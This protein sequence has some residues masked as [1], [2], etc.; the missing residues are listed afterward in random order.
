MDFLGECEPVGTLRTQALFLHEVVRR[1]VTAESNDRGGLSARLNRR[2]RVMRDVQNDFGGS[3]TALSLEVQFGDLLGSGEEHL[4]FD[5]NTFGSARPLPNRNRLNLVLS[6]SVHRSTG[7][8]A[9][10]WL[11]LGLNLRRF[12]KIQDFT[13]DFNGDFFLQNFL[14]VLWRNF[15]VGLVVGSFHRC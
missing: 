9:S 1:R 15:E 8:D 11:F 10:I 5:A 12:F 2:R 14:R 3:F 13:V 4:T 7:Q 6:V